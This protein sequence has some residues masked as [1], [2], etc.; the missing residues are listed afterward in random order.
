MEYL[1]SKNIQLLEIVDIINVD[2]VAVLLN[3][4]FNT[5]SI[6]ATI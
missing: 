6:K 4:E 3:G 1:P 2:C 5:G